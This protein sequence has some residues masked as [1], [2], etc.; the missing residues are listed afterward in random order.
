[1]ATLIKVGDTFINLDTMTQA[2]FKPGSVRLYFAVAT[3]KAGER[4]MDVVELFGRDAQAM[5]RYLEQNSVDVVAMQP[6]EVYD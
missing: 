1:M 5:R 3:G 6:Q 4:H 2:Y